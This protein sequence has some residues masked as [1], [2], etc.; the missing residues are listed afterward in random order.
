MKRTIRAPSPG[1]SD[2]LLRVRERDE[3]RGNASRELFP[4]DHHHDNDDDG[5]VKGC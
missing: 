2:D 1:N 3:R 5:K 4:V